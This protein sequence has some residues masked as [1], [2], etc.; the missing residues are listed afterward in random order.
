MSS[1]Y[2]RFRN[3][4]LAVALLI[5]VPSTFF[6]HAVL[7][8]STPRANETVAGPN[9]EVSL[10]FNSRIDQARSTISLESPDHKV[11]RIAVNSDSSTPQKLAGKVSTLTPGSYELR[12]QVLA[13]DGHITRG[14]INF[15][16]K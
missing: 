5:V 14:V 10:T 1:R 3:A 4:A 16:V 12:W 11:A 2:S 6:G 9:I 7:V 8:G 13:V 15:Q